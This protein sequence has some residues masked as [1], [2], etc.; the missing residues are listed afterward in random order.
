MR[1]DVQLLG[2]KLRS[3]ENQLK[4]KNCFDRVESLPIENKLI[5]LSIPK[6]AS[7]LI[8]DYALPQ[9]GI[10]VKGCHQWFQSPPPKWITNINK[11]GFAYEA[12][13]MDKTQSLNSMSYWYSIAELEQSLVFTVVRNPFDWLASYYFHT[14]SV[15]QVGW[16]NMLLNFDLG[17]TFKH[18]ICNFTNLD[19]RW[20]H[21]D[22]KEFLWHQMFNNSGECCVDV[23]IPY[24]LLSV[25][26][27]SLLKE[28]GVWNNNIDFDKRLQI[29]TA[30]AGKS[31]EELY[32]DEMRSCVEAHC[33]TELQM[34]GYSFDGLS[35]DSPALIY[36]KD[37]IYDGSELKL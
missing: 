18:F 10:E 15:G 11:V 33:A 34:F 32:D 1:S 23:V 7:S 20:P 14:T 6:T 24:E 3:P 8:R 4:L 27:S 36:A 19:F 13:G 2:E 26:L 16:Q 17:K 21:P 12:P 9:S 30:R 29:S 31:Y 5:F 25:G 35:K 22:F 37:L 28:A